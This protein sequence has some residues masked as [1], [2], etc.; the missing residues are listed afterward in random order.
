MDLQ[1]AGGDPGLPD[2]PTVKALPLLCTCL[3][4]EHTHLIDGAQKQVERAVLSKITSRHPE[5]HAH[6]EEKANTNIK[7][8]SSP[9]M[10]CFQFTKRWMR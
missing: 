7:I 3:P 1:P 2:S 8:E 6:F 9:V 5:T 10:S 4:H